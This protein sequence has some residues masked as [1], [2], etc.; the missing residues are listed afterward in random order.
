M[1]TKA[2]IA[3]I[4]IASIGV[5][6]GCSSTT[7][8]DPAP[9]KVPSVAGHLSKTPDDAP[10]FTDLSQK[11]FIADGIGTSTIPFTTRAGTKSISVF[12]ACAT[13]STYAFAVL[14]SNKK[15]TGGSG[16]DCQGANLSGYGKNLTADDKPTSLS[17]TVTAKTPFEITV[18]ES[19]DPLPPS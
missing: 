9:V 19:G 5:L 15:I 17:V 13:S 16:D 18:Y 3:L 11:P 2:T 8:N 10:T 12:V 7:I 14:A 4:S 1:K 6:A